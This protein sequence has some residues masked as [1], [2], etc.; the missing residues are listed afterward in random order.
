MAANTSASHTP[1]Q[2]EGRRG[3]SE[4]HEHD[5]E[6]REACEYWGY[7]FQT[8]KTGTDTLKSLLRGLHNVMVSRRVDEEALPLP[9]HLGLADL[10]SRMKHTSLPRA[11][12]SH[13]INWRISTAIST[14]TMISSS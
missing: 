3:T 8:D 7:L 1:S 5:V 13:Q 14:A 12:T 6:E 9:V 10:A 4:E 11:L 2:E